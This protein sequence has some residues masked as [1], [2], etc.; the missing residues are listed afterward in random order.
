MQH[1]TY[2]DLDGQLA[3]QL[4]ARELMGKPNGGTH[5]GCGGDWTNGSYNGNGNG[6]TGAA[7]ISVGNGNLNGNLNGSALFLGGGVIR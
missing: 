4:P 5:C 2:A 3:E 6:N 1:L 7:L